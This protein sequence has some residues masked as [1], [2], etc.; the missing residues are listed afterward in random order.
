MKVVGITGGI[1]SGKTSVCKII[2]ELGYPVYT[3]DSAAKRLMQSDQN[4]IDSIKLEFGESI[5]NGDMLDK[6]A[7]AKVVFNSSEKLTN[8]NALVHPA[9]AKDFE[10]WCQKQIANIVFKEAAILFETGG[11][12]LLDET[13]LVD[14]PEQDRVNRVM[15]R[16]NVT[17]DVVLV[18]MKNQW[19]DEQKLPLADHVIK[20]Y[21]G[22][23]LLPQIMKLIENLEIMVPKP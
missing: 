13:V 16:D 5:Y 11:Y 18:R 6:P 10:N 3:S 19:P 14:A 23:L 22:Y 20:N 12:K 9:V 15:T 1:G 7:L 17:S 4:L 21:N 8:L 2:E